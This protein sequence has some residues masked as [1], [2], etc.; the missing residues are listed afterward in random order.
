MAVIINLFFVAPEQCTLLK[1]ALYMTE[2]MVS[3]ES[4]R[5][6]HQGFE[7]IGQINDLISNPKEIL[8]CVLTF[9]W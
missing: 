2:N 9:S 3:P 4:V 5:D 6:A 8:V 1:N 7:L